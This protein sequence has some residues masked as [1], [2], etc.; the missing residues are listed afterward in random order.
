MEWKR[1]EKLKEPGRL[2]KP[3]KVDAAL[4]AVILVLAVSCLAA[5]ARTGRSGGDGA[6]GPERLREAAA[7]A[8]PEEDAAP[9]LTLEDIRQVSFTD[10]DGGKPWADCVRY[11]AHQGVLGGTG[12]N[13]FQPEKLVNRATA[14]V[15][16]FRLSGEEAPEGPVPYTDVQAEDWYAGALAWA[17]KAGI[18]EQVFPASEPFSAGR[19]VTRAELAA[20]LS[21]HADYMAS[22]PAAEPEEARQPA[23]EQPKAPRKTRRQTALA[24]AES[25]RET[26]VSPAGA[27]KSQVLVE[28]RPD[29]SG[30]SDGAQVPQALALAAAKALEAGLMK[31]MVANTIYPALPVNRWQLAESLV[32]LTA[33]E[34]E[35]PLAVSLAGQL[36]VETPHSVVRANHAAMSAKVSEIAAKYGAVGLQVAVVEDGAVT[37]AFA[38]GWATRNTDPMTADHKLRVA[39]LSKVS[40]GMAAMVLR[41]QGVI[42]LD[43]SI[44]DYWGFATKNRRYPNTPVSVRALLSHTSTIPMYGDDTSR[45]RSA[46]AAKLQAGDYNSMVPGSVWSWGYN[47]YGF[48]VLGMTLELA[49]HDYLDNILGRSIW[50][51]M[52]IDAAFEGGEIKNTDKLATVYRHDGS[53]GRSIDAQ[54]SYKRPASPGASGS[55]FAGGLTISARDTGKLLALLINDGTY[56]GLRLLSEESVALMETRFDQI[57]SDGTYQALPL[58]S[59]DNIYGR[60]RLYYHTGSAYGVYN[61]MSYDPVER[62]GIVILTTG[63]S[64][65]KDSSGIYAVCGNIARYFYELRKN[66]AAVT[67]A[68]SGTGL[69]VETE[70]LKETESGTVLVVEEAETVKDV[71]GG[72]VLVEMAEDAP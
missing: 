40:V 18:A 10:V 17:V 62:D 26:A 15:T 1:L 61:F 68:S 39:S 45:A 11:M 64:A 16:L 50:S 36:T 22:R 7:Q 29:L 58:R 14:V 71:E 3:G 63:A 57:L 56:Q 38:C 44:G 41:D 46:V 5:A 13:V 19:S 52:D 25:A 2:K 55:S 37:D 43:A 42:D 30:Y 12:T 70:A 20:L 72:T 49:G 54:R 48:S 60:S 23:A 4:A 24:L 31:G 33:L 53:V 59:Q 35:E 69:A 65:S 51:V 21:H 27:E 32:A 6:S 9:A 28:V 47:N 67:E 8:A 66:P 34:T